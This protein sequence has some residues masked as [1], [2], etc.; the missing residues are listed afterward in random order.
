LAHL[1]E[2]YSAIFYWKSQSPWPALR[3]FLY[4]WEMRNVG[5]GFGARSALHSNILHNLHIIMDWERNVI[6]SNRGLEPVAL[7]GVCVM[8]FSAVGHGQGHNACAS[9]NEDEVQPM[10]ARKITIAFN[11]TSGPIPA[12][13]F[14]RF[15][16]NGI[17]VNEYISPEYRAKLGILRADP[18]RPS[19]VVSSNVGASKKVNVKVSLSQTPR[20]PAIVVG[21]H[22]SALLDEQGTEILPL[23]CDLGYFMLMQ[24]EHREVECES[25]VNV[26]SVVVDAFNAYPGS[27]SV[28]SK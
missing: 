1:F 2:W 4:D 28:L 17:V 13:D 22:V 11:G 20:S 14:V 7:D 6:V 15:S 3:G 16:F 26:G 18:E 12:S 10:S 27:S 21:V 23:Y 8:I 25:S 9:K 19:I 5:G 24:G